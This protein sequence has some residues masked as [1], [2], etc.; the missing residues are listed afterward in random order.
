MLFLGLG[1]EQIEKP[2]RTSEFLQ[3]NFSRCSNCGMPQPTSG[4]GYNFGLGVVVCKDQTS[5]KERQKEQ[6]TRSD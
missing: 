5:C 4:L 1:G 2:L 6:R 3:N